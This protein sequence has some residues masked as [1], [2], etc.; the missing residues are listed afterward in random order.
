MEDQAD[1]AGARTKVLAGA[2]AAIC[3][4]GYYRASSNAIAQKASVTWGSIQHHFGSREGLMLAVL[5]DS[6]DRLVRQVSTT[7]VAGDAL[8]TRVLSMLGAVTDFC[9]TPEY[10]AV[11]QIMWNLGSDPSTREETRRRMLSASARVDQAYRDL[12]A[13]VSPLLT[14]EIAELSRK[15][16]WGLGVNLATQTITRDYGPVERKR[17]H[18]DSLARLAEA[19]VFAI[20]AEQPGVLAQAQR[21]VRGDPHA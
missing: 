1:T 9:S 20:R 14:E 8:E 3:E 17:Q 5:E 18:V 13:T 10:L 21:S 16:A 19:I 15:L 4:L 6:V 7:V 11:L 12:A 2:I